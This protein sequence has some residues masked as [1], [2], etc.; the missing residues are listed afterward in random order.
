MIFNFIGHNSADV[1]STST[2]LDVTPIL[3]SEYGDPEIEN[4]LESFRDGQV[5][6]F[7]LNEDVTGFA[8]NF[9]GSSEVRGGYI[10]NRFFVPGENPLVHLDLENSG[11]T[12]ENYTKVKLQAG[13]RIA[14]GY[15]QRGL[16]MQARVSIADR[17]NMEFY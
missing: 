12:A 15:I 7:R 16:G 9:G 11:N 10:H 6:F 8:R 2:V 5:Q 17:E 14:V 3:S 4:Q 1:A 13:T